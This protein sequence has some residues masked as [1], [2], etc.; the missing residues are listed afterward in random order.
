MN[1]NCTFWSVRSKLM[2]IKCHKG[3]LEWLYPNGPQGQIHPGPKTM[4]RELLLFQTR[5]TI[6]YL[7]ILS[8]S[9]AYGCHWEKL[10]GRLADVEIHKGRERV[11]IRKSPQRQATSFVHPILSRPVLTLLQCLRCTTSSSGDLVL[12][13]RRKW[14]N[15]ITMQIRVNMGKEPP[16]NGQVMYLF[17]FRKPHHHH[18]HR[19]GNYIKCFGPQRVVRSNRFK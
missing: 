14:S 6:N 11:K 19:E 16:A 10:C 15:Y 2:Q 3:C 9:G 12:S 13:A 7:S 4:E 5:T 8:S 1:T 17:S 18:Q